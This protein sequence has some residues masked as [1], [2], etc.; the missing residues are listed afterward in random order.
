MGWLTSLLAVDF[1]FKVAVCFLLFFYYSQSCTRFEFFSA[2]AWLFYTLNSFCGLVFFASPPDVSS[3][4]ITTLFFVK[5]FSWTAMGLTF[6]KAILSLKKIEDDFKIILLML[7][8][9]LN[10]FVGTFVA[11]EKLWAVL[12][13]LI[14]GGFSLLGCAVYFRELKLQFTPTASQCVFYGFL[15]NGVGSFGQLFIDGRGEFAFLNFFVSL[16]VT[17]IFAAG[18][19]E[20][21]RCGTKTSVSSRIEG[22]KELSVSVLDKINGIN[23]CDADIQNIFQEILE[24]SAKAL[25]LE[26]GVLY[27]LGEDGKF[28]LAKASLNIPVVLRGKMLQSI[29]I[30]RGL[31]GEIVK[32]GEVKIIGDIFKSWVYI[33]NDIPKTFITLPLKNENYILGCLIFVTYLPQAFAQDEI[34][35][36]EAAAWKISAVL[37]NA[38]KCISVKKTALEL[39]T[40]YNISLSLKPYLNMENLLDEILKKVVS[41]LS[42][43]G[44]AIYILNHKEDNFILRAKIGLSDEFAN[45]VRNLSLDS[46]TFGAQVARTRK[47]VCVED[48]SIYPTPIQKAVQKEK[49]CGY[50][51]VPIISVADKILGTL[52]VTTR[53]IRKFKDEEVQLLISISHGIATAV[54][55]AK[56]YEDLQD[57][58][59]RSVTALTEVVDAKDHYTYSH[60]KYVTAFAVKIASEM[61]LPDKEVEIVRKAC[62]LHDIG[63]IGIN[64]YILT[65]KRRLNRKEWEEV[66]KHPQKGAAILEPLTFLKEPKGGVIE[67]I[68]QHHE[69]YNGTGYP[70]G[71]KGEDIELGARIMAVADA[72]HAMI[73]NRPYRRA[74]SQKKAV[75]ELMRYS[76]SQ[77]DPKVVE[78]FLRILTKE[79]KYVVAKAQ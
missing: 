56:L 2:L 78:A 58:Y 11:G 30:G 5:Y 8:A 7:L 18:L 65:K 1:G 62:Q 66:K 39:G 76:N 45:S 29:E 59:L 68:K 14:I 74:L 67:L 57:V 60:S 9:V 20:I 46:G 72:Y 31:I 79:K 64:D 55:N 28:L 54:E 24:K 77:F 41:A 10:G 33:K 13:C 42:V 49:L 36:F 26:A 75:D 70:Q 34:G 15:L 50:C 69:K 47:A 6:L 25:K 44:G 3:Y 27:V 4:I 35:L 40:L 43:E 38:K 19:I 16:A 63:K 21:S 22:D 32:A 17:V 37:R 61:K 52:T 71:L 73:S 53:E 51:G 48:I 23:F 12:L